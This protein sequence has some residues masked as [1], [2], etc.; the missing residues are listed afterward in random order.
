[1]R[2]GW[3]RVHYKTWITKKKGFR[4]KY[5]CLLRL[6]GDRSNEASRGKNVEIESSFRRFTAQIQFSSCSF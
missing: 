2:G 1:M 3:A 6:C 5:M 4:I